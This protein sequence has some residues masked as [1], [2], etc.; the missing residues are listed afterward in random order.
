MK[1]IVFLLVL[2][3]LF[4]F[5]QDSLKVPSKDLQIAAA[6]MAAPEDLRAG[7]TVYGFSPEGEMITL[8][9]GTNEMICLADDPKRDGF[10]VAA[11]HSSLEPFMARGRQLRAEGKSF[12]E[13]REIRGAE[14][15]AGTLKMPKDG[16]TLHILYGKEGYY[17]ADSGKVVNAIY[18]YVVYIPWATTESTG[19][20]MTPTVKGAPWIMDPGTHRAHI[21]INPPAETQ[22]F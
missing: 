5:G 22:E 9:E 8:R 13:V 12:Q 16:T 21:M 11:Y 17:D 3:T 19:L 7:A 4:A 6:V 1:F 14:A 18:R 20:P 2:S 10:N 15:K